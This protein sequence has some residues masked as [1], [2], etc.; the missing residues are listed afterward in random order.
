V[1]P[2]LATADALPLEPGFTQS[3]RTEAQG[4]SSRAAGLAVPSP[5]TSLSTLAADLEARAAALPA[6][7]GADP[8]L[9][10]LAAR[11]ASLRG[12][13]LNEEERARLDAGPSLP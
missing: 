4:L 3:L 5:E 11:A 2:L 13:G 7:S 10:E 8:R 6:P 9:A 1:A 12:Q